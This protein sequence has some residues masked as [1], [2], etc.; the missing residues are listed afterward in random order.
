MWEKEQGNCATVISKA[1]SLSPSEISYG[2]QILTLLNRTVRD[3]VTELSKEGYPVYYAQDV[4]DLAK[5][6]HTICNSDSY[7]VKINLQNYFHDQNELVHPNI[8]GHEAWAQSLIAWSQTKEAQVVNTTM[9]EE[10]GGLRSAAAGSL[11]RL[12]RA[13]Q[14]P[15]DHAL[16]AQLQPLAADGSASR[17]VTTTTVR[18]GDTLTLTVTGVNPGSTVTVTVHSDIQALGALTADANGKASGTLA[19]T[20][21]LPSGNH[22]LV[23]E[24]LK[25]DA[26]MGYYEVPLSVRETSGWLVLLAYG[27]VLLLIAGGAMTL[28]LSTRRRHHLAAAPTASSTSVAADVV[29]PE[30]ADDTAEKDADTEETSS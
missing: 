25:E 13:V 1:Y 15:Q 5:P 24:G 2:R 11:K 14:P 19:L 3:A 4:V 23:L 22:T 18:T 7:F 9:P 21:D 12:G 29:D 6:N 26:Q 28:V 20:A 8:T 27:I 30:G 10:G 17:Q 16:S